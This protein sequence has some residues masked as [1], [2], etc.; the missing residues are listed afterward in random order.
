MSLLG[1]AGLSL[2]I[3]SLLVN[4][5]FVFRYLY[6]SKSIIRSI[7][8]KLSILTFTLIYLLLVIELFLYLSFAHFF[9]HTE[10]YGYTL[11][12]ER[13][14]DKYWKPINSL[15]YRDINHDESDFSGK[16]VI[17]VVG[18]SF[19]AGF[20]I[21][22]YENRFS[23]V[24]QKYLGEKWLVINIAQMGWDTVDEYKAILSYPVNPDFIILSYFIDDCNGAAAKMGIRLNLPLLCPSIR[25]Y[26]IRSYLLNF[27]YWRLNRL[28]LKDKLEQNYLEYLKRIHM[29]ERSWQTHKN[30]ILDIVDYAADQNA[31]IIAVV[32][33][34]LTNIKSSR[35]FTSK[36]VDLM[37][38]N[39]VIVIDLADKLAERDP[40]E[41]VVSP[42]DGHPSMSLHREVAGEL[43]KIINSMNTKELTN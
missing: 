40:L 11:A 15:G 26:A 34:E 27:I 33:P 39:Q 1:L 42:L 28:I 23:N 18:D 29:D 24:L 30:E 20:G 8:I 17:F 37:N 31:E 13:W 5:V 9:V 14:L 25:P 21:E 22:D 19:A 4:V 38:H 32:F 10:Q 41:L 35:E 7:L 6:T 3:L 12:T 2:L 36:V 16:K 43:F